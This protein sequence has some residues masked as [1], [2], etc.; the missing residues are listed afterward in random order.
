VDT[1]SNVQFTRYRK[2]PTTSGCFG[3]VAVV[4]I[5]ENEIVVWIPMNLHS[6]ASVDVWVKLH[7]RLLSLIPGLNKSAEACKKKFNTLFKQY[8][9][10]KMANSVSGEGRH[11]CK[12][13]DS[14]DQ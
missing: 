8:K 1:F 7:V 5:L 2:L 11:E 6:C 3:I 14:I 13:Y 4:Q 9:V 10:D 12:F